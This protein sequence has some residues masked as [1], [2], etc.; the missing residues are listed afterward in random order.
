MYAHFRSAAGLA[1][2]LV[3]LCLLSALW[4][5]ATAAAADFRRGPDL[6][7]PRAGLAAALLPDGRVLVAGSTSTDP[8]WTTE[9]YDP[10]RQRWQAGPGLP[11]A[12]A[13]AS[14]TQLPTG[15]VLLVGQARLLFDPATNRWTDTLP[16]APELRRH[17]ATLLAGGQV[18]V[19][20]G[21]ARFGGEYDTLQS[22]DPLTGGWY[23][24]GRMS[25]GRQAHAAVRLPS[26]KVL[27]AGGR[28]GGAALSSADVFDPQW[29]I[30]ENGTASMLAPRSGLSLTVLGNGKVLAA[31]GSDGAASQATCE[32]YDPA[33]GTWQWAAPMITARSGHA[34]TL[35]PDGR[36]LAS[37]GESAPGVAATT[38]DIYDPVA[39]DWSAVVTL[40]VP[41]AG[42]AAVLMGSGSVLL[43]GGAGSAAAS[44]SSEWFDPATASTRYVGNMFSARAGGTASALPPGKVLVVGGAGLPSDD[45]TVAEV[46]DAGTGSW[47]TVGLLAGRTRHT[48]TVLGSGKVLLAGGL[49]GGAPTTHSETVN[50]ST[51]ASAQVAH[52]TLP[53][54][55][56]TASLLGDGTVLVV[57][58]YSTGTVA[59]A[60]IE[61]YRPGLDSWSPGAAMDTARAEH[62][63]TLLGDG[64]V[65]VS[66]GRD[67]AGQALDS[68]ELYDPVADSWTTVAAPGIA[69]YG[70]SAFLLR[71]GAV[72]VAGGFG[73][74]EQALAR[75][76]LFD[77]QTLSWRRAG[78]L[79]QARAQHTATLLPSGQVLVTGGV[80]A[81]NVAL[82]SAEIYQPD[83]DR[84][85]PAAGITMARARHVAALLPSG[86]LL[87]THGYGTNWVPFWEL[88]DLGLARDVARQPRLHSVD[89]LSGGHGTVRA[90]GSGWRPAAS[91]DSGSAV[92][93]ASNLPLLQIERVDSG[94]MRFVPADTALPFSDGQFNGRPL[95][96]ADF[97]A[98]PVW[99]RAWVNGIPSAALHTTLASVPAMLPAPNAS[100]GVLRAT[101]TFA[102]AG[103]DG[104]AP[105]TGYRVTAQP[106]GAQRSCLVPCSSV[107]F[108]TLPPGNYTFSA[109][110]VNAAGVAAASALSNSVV[111]QARSSVAL[112]SAAN[113]STYGAAV[114]FT[115][116]VSGQAP[117]GTVSFRA[118][119]N[120]L[121]S[122]VPLS[123]GVAQCTS[124]SLAGGMHAVSASYAGDIGNT[125]AQSTTLY[126]QVNTLASQ[127]ALTSSANP[128]RYGDSVVL[129]ATI[130]TELL[131]GHVDF[132]DGT[133]ALCTHVAL[134]GGTASCTVDNFTVGTHAITARYSGDGDTG[135]SVS[136]ALAQQVL[137]L[138]TTTSVASD[139]SRTFSANQPFTLQASIAGSSLG[140]VP[141]GSV[142]FVTDSGLT[143]CQT[144]ALSA[145]TARCTT[146][147]LVA[148]AGQGQGVVAIH[149][150]YS[151]DAINAAGSS[152]E[153]VVT[154]IDPADVLLRNGVEAAVSGC[155]AR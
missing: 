116:S 15:K 28:N 81:G 42:H 34:A 110:A 143:L 5:A 29:N 79:A 142:D 76:D 146:T 115:A 63:A 6:T 150:R 147:A 14:L 136:F 91:G 102:A 100:G 10:A 67:V 22:F 62:T 121:C 33:T 53:R 57:G 154:V 51:L 50:G 60:A 37:G 55:A 144:V 82:Q 72:L 43:V 49:H 13:F 52:M 35:L 129:S 96:L 98:G 106:G 107:E 155:P 130:T 114:T 131:G 112:V 104:G 88:Y 18:L 89:L 69:R 54:H 78:D 1:G 122:D 105:I 77:P 123:A 117:G 45:N 21:E 138:P 17:T 111:V 126:Q 141:G 19:T 120:V 56:H 109:S 44:T 128:A 61:R 99:V 4:P 85:V 25:L 127:A 68:A 48:Q 9:L 119:G 65:L 134:A 84:W 90:S 3:L 39:N 59:T 149:A 27:I 75:A 64:R 41:R 80:S 40:A 140:G 87:I 113:P 139:C 58:G 24:A 133:T 2:G 97:P 11:R 108:E 92:G 20:G 101:V 93:A 83:S 66:G 153:L 124:S 94:Q 118:D 74:G 125:D 23:Y 12:E 26:G 7:V 8:A 31:G 47:T 38:A 148:P 151:G 132:H 30:I 32:I 95:A 103:D 71:S 70:A 73:A 135:A 46:F 145:A 86:Q 36:V 137:A 152:P 16:G